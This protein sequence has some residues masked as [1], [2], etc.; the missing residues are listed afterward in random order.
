VPE[1]VLRPTGY[2]A[3]TRGFLTLYQIAVL[4]LPSQTYDWSSQHKG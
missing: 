1:S 2:T 3:K 4:T